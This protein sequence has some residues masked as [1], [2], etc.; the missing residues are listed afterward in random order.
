MPIRFP[1]GPEAPS[2]FAVDALLIRE[3]GPESRGEITRIID[4]EPADPEEAHDEPEVW[5]NLEAGASSARQ[6]F[7][8]IL[9][10]PGRN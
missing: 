3:Y 10:I 5:A 7:D 8:H 9:T 6:K 1:A 2:I 4:V